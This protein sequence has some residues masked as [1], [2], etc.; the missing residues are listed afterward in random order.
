MSLLSAGE[1]IDWIPFPP[2]TLEQLRDYAESSGDYNPIHLEESEAK[3]AGLPG[4]IAHGMLTAG[5]LAE[6][7]ER[8][9]RQR[10]MLGRC[11]LQRSKFRFKSMT[12]PGDQISIGGQVKQADEREFTLELQAKNQRGEVTTVSVF[13]YGA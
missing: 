9:L 1:S 10:E 4:I 8:F 13:T 7:A 6:R 11:R 5:L 12:L 2:I 3:K